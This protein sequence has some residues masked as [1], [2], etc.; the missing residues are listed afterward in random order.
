MNKDLCIFILDLDGT[1][2]GN[3]IY[4]IGLYNICSLLKK[5]GLKSEGLKFL[6]ECYQSKKLLLRPFFID[7][8]NY[9]KKN[10]SNYYVFIYTASDKEWA[11][12]EINWIEKQNKDI[13]FNRPIFTRQECLKEDGKYSKSITRILPKIKKVVKQEISEENIIIIDDNNVY[14]DFQRNLL[15]C[16]YYNRCLFYDMWS[17]IPKEAIKHPIIGPLII[18]YIQH[19]TINPTYTNLCDSK[20]ELKAKGHKWFN[21]K[22]NA[23]SFYNKN[24][25]NDIFWK[26][27]IL[28]LHKF[29]NSITLL[30]QMK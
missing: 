26:K 30:P 21:K 29:N 15:I 16:P 28:F 25:V 1:I 20:T 8:M 2:I 10:F 23:C 19:E 13:K 7:F 5:N 18:E 22:F 24:S 27:V 12:K 17:F 11:Y 14:N 3:V 9:L 6:P 4:Q